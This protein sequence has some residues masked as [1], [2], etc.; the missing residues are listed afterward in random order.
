MRHAAQLLRQALRVNDDPTGPRRYHPRV[1]KARVLGAT[2]PDRP[3]RGLD[4]CV[5]L[6]P[7]ADLRGLYGRLDDGAALLQLH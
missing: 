3:P 6:I 1:R 5:Q 7:I 2:G 4:L